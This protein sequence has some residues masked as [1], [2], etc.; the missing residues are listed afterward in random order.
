MKNFRLATLLKIREQERDRAAKEVMDARNAIQK[1]EAAKAEVQE[2]NERINE[3]RKQ[4]SF[5]NVNMQSIL[6]AQRFQ[7]LLA[8]QVQQ[9]DDH[10]GK[11]NQ[12]LQRRE[13]KLLECQQGVKSLEKLKQHQEENWLASEN[14]RMQMQTDEW[15]SVRF[16]EQ[17]STSQQSV[18]QQMKVK[19]DS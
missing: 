11:L 17:I 4:A 5:G 14:N 3:F 10:L 13:S 15:A 7:M 19:E 8:A 1:L 2:E 6:D 12:E 9:L 16:A 18:S